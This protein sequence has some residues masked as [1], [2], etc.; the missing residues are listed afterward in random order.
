[1]EKGREREGE[2]EKEREA[3]REMERLS[4]VLLLHR[5]RGKQSLALSLLMA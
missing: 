4:L 2:R 1:M 3:E 5:T